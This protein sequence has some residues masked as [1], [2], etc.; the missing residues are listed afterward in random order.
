[1]AVTDT[2]KDAAYVTIGLGV[3][4]FQRAQVRR[5]ELTKQLEEQ[6]KVLESQVAEGRKAVAGIAGQL[7]DIVGPVRSQ[8]ETQLEAIESALPAG[9]AEVFKQA[10]TVAHQTE[11]TVRKSFGFAA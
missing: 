8:I 3:L 1:M 7:D 6:V 11:Q 9:V 4:G 10:R 5:V 2:L